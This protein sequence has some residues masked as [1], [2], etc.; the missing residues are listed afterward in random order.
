M[1]CRDRGLHPINADPP[2]TFLW[3]RLCVYPSASTPAQRPRSPRGDWTR[4]SRSRGLRDRRRGLSRGMP[5]FNGHELWRRPHPRP[6]RR[7]VGLA[8]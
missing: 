1:T 7:R 4:L 5:K 8:S 3:V 2:E 6:R